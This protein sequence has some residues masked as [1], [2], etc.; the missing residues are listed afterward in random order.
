MG[1]AK[2]GSADEGVTPDHGDTPIA[3]LHESHTLVGRIRRRLNYPLAGL[4]LLAIPMGCLAAYGSWG[5]RQAFGLFSEWVHGVGRISTGLS[6]M[7]LLAAGGL[8]FGLILKS[9]GWLRFRGPAHVI[10]AVQERGGRLSIRDGLITAACDAL[11]LGMGASVGRYGPA[12]QLGA[13]VGSILGRSL[14][15]SRSGIRVLLACGVAAAISASFNAPL[16]GVLFAHEV[17]IGSFSLRAFAPITVGS[18]VAVG[19]TRYHGFE[20]VALKLTERSGHLV[21]WEYPAYLLLGVLSAVVAVVYMT[22]VLRTGDLA[23]R[24]RLPI[25][26][27]PAIGGALAGAVGL[28][29]PEVLGLGETTM[30]QVLDPELAA[31]V[32]G[33][34]LVTALWI[35]K[36]LASVS[37]LGLRYPGGVFGPAIFMGAAFG[38]MVGFVAPFLDY[39]ICVLVGMGAL[40][41]AVIGAPLATVLIVFELTENYQAASAVMMGVVAANALVTR[42]YARSIFHRQI[43]RWG[44][45]LN[46]PPEQRLMRA[47]HV[48]EIMSASFLAVPPDRT[49]GEMSALMTRRQ[50]GDMFVIDPQS[51]R[52]LGRLPLTVLLGAGPERTA[53][54]LCEPAE[55]WLQASDNLWD[56]FLRMETFVGYAAPVVA[57][58]ASMSILGVVTEG[59]L[60]AAYRRTLGEVR[61]DQK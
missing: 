17:I 39:Q 13:T 41:S 43:Q 23:D 36:L 47:R 10:V 1:S 22:G 35:A 57:D 2:A 59:D 29:M 7:L 31:S 46:R 49:A 9:L 12:L 26:I 28:W 34:G 11:A 24:M 42:Y 15:L 60:I 8:V 45:D 56:A 38:A 33:I 3:E 4:I 61:E 5:F 58:A 52:L 16:A 14:G 44:I 40:V 50:E 37:C 19:V 48:D 30:Q 55:F 21:L 54:E 51:R 27:Q 53:G 20:Y 6:Q 32:Y 25:W 18:V